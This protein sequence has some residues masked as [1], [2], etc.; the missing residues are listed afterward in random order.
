MLASPSR[1]PSAE[2]P[3]RLHAVLEAI[4][5]AY[6]S[7]WEDVSGD[8]PKLQGLADEALWLGRLTAALLPEEPEPRGL[9]ALML[10]SEA[11]RGA[12]R[13]PD[14]QY[15]PLSEQGQSRWSV[16]LISEAERTL[17]SAAGLGH[18][19]PYQLEA[20][21]QSAHVERARTGR[22]NDE[23]IALLYEGLVRLSPTLGAQV[24]RVSAL[25]KVQGAER[26]LQLLEEL[27][28]ELCQEYQPYWALR[29]HLLDAAGQPAEAR[30]AY[31]C[32]LGM[33]G[34]PSIRHYLLRK[35][36]A[37]PQPH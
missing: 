20:A 18:L 17:G 34:D 12:R 24:A 27:P 35:L 21:I 36:Q 19:G 37:L 13:T 25:A 9:Q 16:E 6:G 32:A 23:A 14:G 5:A 22:V 29:G 33:T 4:Y 3:A 31:E 30:L 11:R 28:G 26:G 8:G 1:S 10:Y 7:G 2:L 15:V